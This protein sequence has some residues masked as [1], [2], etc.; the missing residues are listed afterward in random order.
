[1]KRIFYLGLAWLCV[2][3]GVLGAFLPLLPTT[4]FLLVALWAFMRSSPRLEQWLRNHKMLGPYITDWDEHG[5]V[6]VR[7]KILAVSMMAASMVWL[8][9]FSSAS[10]LVVGLVG[11]V[12]AAVATWLITRPSGTREGRS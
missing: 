11:L 6:P 1:M 2:G 9:F 4:P 7:A 10:P 8:A 5:I 3:A 12:L